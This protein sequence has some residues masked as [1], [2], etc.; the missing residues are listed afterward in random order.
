[1][2]IFG[3]LEQTS[4]DIR[5]ALRAMAKNPLFTAT[6]ALSLAL[7][8]GANTAIYSFMDA[9]MMRSLPA[10][11]PE[12]LAILEWHSARRSAVV[13]GINGSARRYGKTGTTSP[14]F[15]YSAYQI[16]RA[17]RQM[18]STLFAYTYA[19]NFNVI[20]RGEAE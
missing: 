19:Q 1:M 9:I 16:L 15:P 7:G 18:F 4:Q 13:R 14:N 8:I 2:S 10:A 6:A 11:P 17:N 5:Y 12:Q 20:A 3:F